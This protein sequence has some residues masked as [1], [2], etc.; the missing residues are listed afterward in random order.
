[1]NKHP[2]LMGT[3]IL[4]VTG[5]LS[6]ILGFFYRIFLS[7]AIGA[8]GLGLYQM[9]FPV[10]GIAFA[11]CAG[12][13][14]TAISQLVASGARRGREALR[15]GLFISLSIAAALTAS[16]F[17]FHDAW[18]SISCWSRPAARFCRSWPCPFRSA[19]FTRVSAATTMG[20]GKPGCPPSPSWWNR[21]YGFFLYFLW[22][23]YILSRG[24]R[25]RWRWPSGPW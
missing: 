23:I 11:L 25:S 19:R 14:Q 17:C 10:H 21:S 1:M 16:I 24:R 3:L 18:Q 5:F 2:I 8:E 9:I 22:R 12:S 7:R 20:S 4:T 13:I 6:R 15:T